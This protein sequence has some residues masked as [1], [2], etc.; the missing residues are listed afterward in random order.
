MDKNIN[1]KKAWYKRVWVWLLIL[2]IL[3]V[4]GVG[5]SGGSKTPT[6]PT[7][8]DTKT[9]TEATTQPSGAKEEPKPEKWDMVVAYDKITNGMTKAQVEEV[10]GKTSDTCTES[11]MGQYGKS[12][13]CSYG[14]AFIDKAQIIVT[15]SNGEVSTKTKTTY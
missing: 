9:G 8:T 15:Y 5:A 10:T 1:Q 7:T 12:E 3:I 11:D 4:I 6:I 14:N 13:T 2:V